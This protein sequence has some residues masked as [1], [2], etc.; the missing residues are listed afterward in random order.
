MLLVDSTKQ[1][2]EWLNICN[3]PTQHQERSVK[4]GGPFFF[5]NFMIAISLKIPPIVIGLSHWTRD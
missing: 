4:V 1:M 2:G 5:F 3:S